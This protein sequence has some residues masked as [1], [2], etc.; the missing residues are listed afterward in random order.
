MPGIDGEHGAW[1]LP[2]RGQIG[3]REFALRL[4]SEAGLEAPSRT[5]DQG[6]AL[7]FALTS[8]RGWPMPDLDDAITRFVRDTSFD[9]SSG[10]L[11]AAE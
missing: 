6:P 8:R 5:S 3:I 7:N 9:Q 4:A 10:A 11:I 2:N 1:H